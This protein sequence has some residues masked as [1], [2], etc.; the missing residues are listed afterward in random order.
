[1]PLLASQ[2]HPQA[3]GRSQMGG[4]YVLTLRGRERLTGRLDGRLLYRVCG[5]LL[6]D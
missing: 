1:M 6:K 3:T 5:R 2:I 4:S